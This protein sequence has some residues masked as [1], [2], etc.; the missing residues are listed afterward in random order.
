MKKLFLISLLILGALK[1]NSQSIKGV[2]KDKSTGETIPFANVFL[3]DSNKNKIKGVSTDFDGLYT[4]NNIPYGNYTLSVHFIGYVKQE[5]ANI[6]ITDS[7]IKTVDVLLSSDN[8]KMNEIVV[9]SYESKLFSVASVGGITRARKRGSRSAGFVSNYNVEPPREKYNSIKDNSFKKVKNEPLSTLSIDVD[10]AAYANVRRFLTDGELPPVDA[11]RIEEMINYFNYDY[12]EP[13][14]GEVFSVHKEFGVCPWDEKHKLVQIGI[15]G[16]SIKMDESLKNNI[17]LLLDVSGSMSSSDKLGL[18]QSGLELLI[19]QLNENDKIAIVVYAGSSGVVLPSTKGNRKEKIKEAINK[20]QTGGST[21][22]GEGIN[23]AYKIAQKNFI[24][25]G[26]NRII[27]ATDGDFN[28]GL[29]SQEELVNLIKEKRN[30]GVFLS[31]IGVGTGNLNDG[32][33][34]QLADKGNGNYN[35]LDNI[36]EAKKVFVDEIGGTLV[37]IAKDVKLQVEFN[38]NNVKAYRLI[39]YTNRLLNAEDFND[40]KKDAGELGSGHTVTFLYEIIPA[41]SNEVVDNIDSLK[42]QNLS[43]KNENFTNEVLTLKFR[44]KSPNEDTSK[45]ITETLYNAEVPFNE[46]SN[47]FKFSS[48]VAAFGMLLRDKKFAKKMDA[49]HIIEI[50]KSAKGEDTNGYRAEFIKLVETAELLIK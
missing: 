8:V 17:V 48:S 40:D 14:K 5:L 46:L 35:Y 13:K 31:V 30:E 23:L 7:L 42:Y 16:E 9:T 6:I 26:N 41:S 24:K 50:A 27:L 44:Y 22:G 47:N 2:V 28:V 37:T 12:P 19:D 32:M 39:G 20:L 49:K 15:K 3:L 34:E 4:M 18:I 10:R 25:E 11:V 45:L 38:P 29:S 21:A 36:L 33:M 43:A 1:G